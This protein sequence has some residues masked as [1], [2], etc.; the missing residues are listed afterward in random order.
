MSM[1]RFADALDRYG[2]D[3]A[4]WPTAARDFAQTLVAQSSEA[5]QLL[6]QSAALDALIKAHDP[7]LTISPHSAAR[8][9]RA[10]L[11][12]I[13]AE[14]EPAPGLRQRLASLVDWWGGMPRYAAPLALGLALGLAFGLGSQGHNSTLVTQPTP[15]D[16]YAQTQPL[17]PMGL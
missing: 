1:D 5:A 11:S 14:S 17:S 2:S 9:S 4:N 10:V 13:A 15:V 12:R 7:A 3:I 8:V 6:H 16:L